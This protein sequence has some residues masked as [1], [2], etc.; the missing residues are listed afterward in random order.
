MTLKN[1][2]RPTLYSNRQADHAPGLPEC[3]RLS[4]RDTL[5]FPLLSPVPRTVWPDDVMGP[6]GPQDQR[7]QL[8]GNVGFDAHVNGVSNRGKVQVQRNLPD[9]LSEPAASERHEFVMAQFV[10]EFQVQPII[11]HP[12]LRMKHPLPFWD[13]EIHSAGS[14][15]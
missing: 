12:P 1:V 5:R 15:M 9:L 14:P 8:P 4:V 11:L 3:D 6:F 10:N 7:F 2:S 13:R